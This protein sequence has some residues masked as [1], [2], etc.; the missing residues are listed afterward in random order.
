MRPFYR[1]YTT[2][3][4]GLFEKITEMRSKIETSKTMNE[5]TLLQNDVSQIAKTLLAVAE[6][7]PDLKANMSFMN[8]QK[9]IS[10]I[11]EQIQYARRYYNGTVRDYNTLILSFPSNIVANL[12]NFKAEDFFEIELA[13]QKQPP[14]VK[15]Q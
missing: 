9:N 14:E 5:K 15:L 8:L 13:T 7:Y 12:F 2:Y 6:A 4:K 3:E 1:A 10:D 11:E